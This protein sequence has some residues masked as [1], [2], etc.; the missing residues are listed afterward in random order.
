MAIDGVS[1]NYAGSSN[2]QPGGVQKDNGLSMDDF[3]QLIAAQLQ[4]QNMLDPVDNT[5]YIAQM[6]Q[7]S[8]LSKLN[9]IGQAMD[10]IYAMSMLGKTVAVS[11]T[12]DN[13]TTESK[14]GVVEEIGYSGG[15][16]YLMIDGSYYGLSDIAAVAPTIDTNPEEG[17]DPSENG[18]SPEADPSAPD[19]SEPAGGA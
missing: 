3:F 1:S 8:S 17:G 13:G 18:G 16:P 19:A 10:K 11:I 12:H 9:E 2:S 15:S 6:A 5:E 14:V 4:N 7:F